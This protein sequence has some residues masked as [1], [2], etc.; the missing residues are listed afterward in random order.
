[1]QGRRLKIVACKRGRVAGTLLPVM[2]E[3]TIRFRTKFQFAGGVRARFSLRAPRSRRSPSL[4]IYFD[5][6]E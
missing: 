1:M 3:M 2:H 5:E 6:L 4:T